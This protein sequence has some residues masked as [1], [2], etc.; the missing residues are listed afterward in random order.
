M[1]DLIFPL[2][3]LEKKD[4]KPRDYIDHTYHNTLGDFNSGKYVVKILGFDPGTPE[5]WFFLKLV[6]RS[7]VAWNITTGSWKNILKGFS[8]LKPKLSLPSRLTSSQTN[9]INQI[10]F[11]SSLA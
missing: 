3:P 5:K 9:T 7:I 4:F 8:K 10:V 1:V 6:Q 2:E 11:H